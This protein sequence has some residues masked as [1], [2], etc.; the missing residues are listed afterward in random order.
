MHAPASTAASIQATFLLGSPLSSTGGL[1]RPRAS[2]LGMQLRFW[3]QLFCF[4][5]SRRVYKYPT[6]RRQT[7]REGRLVSDA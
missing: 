6:S 3:R 1:L 2:S 4:K 7:I 5:N